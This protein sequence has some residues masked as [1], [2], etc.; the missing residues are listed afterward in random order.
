M[1]CW[2]LLGLGLR[3]TLL[4]CIKEKES[5]IKKV[6]VEVRWRWYTGAGTGHRISDYAETGGCCRGTR[7]GMAT[8]AIVTGQG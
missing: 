1:P 6:L 2:K 5:K 4:N 3:L 8:V 7:L